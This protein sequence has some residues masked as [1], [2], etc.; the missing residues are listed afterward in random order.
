MLVNMMRDTLSAY[1]T[2]GADFTPVADTFKN[3]AKG[4]Q[5]LERYGVVGG[6][7][8]AND[9]DNIYTDFINEQNRRAKKFTPLTMFRTVWDGLGA[10]TTRSDAATRKAVYDDVL[11]RTGNEAEAAYQA[12]E[13]INFSR[14]GSSAAA[15]ILTAAI[16]FLNARFQGLDVLY[17][18]VRG[19]YSAN[20]QLSKAKR[21]QTFFTR[22]AYLTAISAA[23]WMLMHDEEEYKERSEFEKDNNYI[24]PIKIDGRYPIKLPIP[25]EIGL[26]FKTFPERILDTFY[27]T[28]TKAE[29]AESVKRGVGS[30][31]MFN[32]LEAQIISPFME[33]LMNKSFYTGNPIESVF[34]NDNNLQAGMRTK[35]NTSVLAQL[36]GEGLNVSPIMADHVLNGYAGTLGGYVL[37][38]T[39][40]ILRQAPQLVGEEKAVPRSSM[41]V[42]EMPLARKFI[43]S[44][45]GA[46]F[47]EDFYDVASEVGRTVGTVNKLAENNDLERLQRYLVGREHLLGMRDSVNY[48]KKQLK[49]FRDD[50]AAIERS[51][52]PPDDKQRIKREIELNRQVFLR[53][54]SHFK[55]V[56][57]K[58][59]DF[60]TEDLYRD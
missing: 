56:A 55:N 8:F 29:L 34:M 10:A 25:F 5:D 18:S 53:S 22:A 12:L 15:R 21:V 28:T 9:P 30:T 2:S 45:F 27:G 37:Q 52:L 24:L 39:D 48:V 57:N 14:R 4:T 7:D 19:Q 6:Y 59:V 58:P 36:I 47:S 3:F 38:A 26:L 20:N 50:L 33:V 35:V 54:T 51:D 46:G 44:E 32:P 16:P 17:R 23:Y 11:A 60:F 41:T 49:S 1:V 13:V 31:L 40:Y 43:M 42:A